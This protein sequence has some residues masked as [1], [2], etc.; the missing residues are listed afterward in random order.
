MATVVIQ[1]RPRE[2]GNSYVITYKDPNSGRKRY[3]KTFRKANEARQAANDLRYL[4]DNGKVAS[5]QKNYRKSKLLTVDEACKNLKRDWRDKAQNKALSPVTVEGYLGRLGQIA[6]VFGKRF[7]CEITEKEILVYRNAIAKSTSNAN[8]NRI[9]FVVKQIFSCGEELGAIT[10]NP[11]SGIKMLSEKAHERNCFLLPDSLMKLLE[12]CQQVRSRFYLVAIIFLGAE[13]GASKQEILSLKWT[14][15]DFN[16]EGKGLIHFFRTKNKRERTEILMP[17][18]REALLSWR[19][20]LNE[21]RAKR[22]IHVENDTYV[23]CRLDGTRLKGFTSGWRKVRKLAGFDDLHFHDLRH[24]FCSNLMLAG[25][26]MKDIKDM[27]GH[28]EIKMTDRYTHLTDARKVALQEKLAKHYD[29]M[30]PT[31]GNDPPSEPVKHW[32]EG[33]QGNT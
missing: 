13:H 22:D 5:I 2:N 18:T 12:A 6:S 27:I 4:L 25:A 33:T 10:E 7:L 19:S 1:K 30:C 14:D 23:F 3:Y 8:A 28:S 31:E 29:G 26:N 20:H 15:L 16:H 32:W 17:R 24:T 11:L 9:L 21:M